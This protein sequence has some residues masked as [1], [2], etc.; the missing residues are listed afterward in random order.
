[1]VKL[2]N[3][4]DEVDA[5]GKGKGLTFFKV[6][7]VGAKNEVRLE[8]QKHDG[9]FL[10]LDPQVKKLFGGDNKNRKS[11]FNVYRDN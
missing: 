2:Y 8:S 4:N 10:E 5:A 11:I 1:M 9:K 3:L 7:Q 6:H